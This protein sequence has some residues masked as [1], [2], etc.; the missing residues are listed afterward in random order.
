MQ[1]GYPYS[2]KKLNSDLKV[3]LQEYSSRKFSA[4]FTQFAVVPIRCA[5]PM[6]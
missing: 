2:I 1:S 3:N 4:A 6:V 5:G